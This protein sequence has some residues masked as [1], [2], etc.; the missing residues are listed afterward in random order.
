MWCAWLISGI[1][2]AVL[3]L[4]IGLGFVLG[5]YL[6]RH[7]GGEYQTNEAKDAQLFDDADYAVAASKTGQPD[8]K[9]S[10]EWYI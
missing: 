2:A 1:L 4:L 9:K 10:K 7:Q 8:F 3:L 6:Y 5:R